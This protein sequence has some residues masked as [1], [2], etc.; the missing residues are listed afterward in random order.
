MQTHFQQHKRTGYRLNQRGLAE[1]LFSQGFLRQQKGFVGPIGDDIPSLIPLTVALLVFFGAFGFAFNS[2]EE[3]K[4]EFDQRLILLSV[5]KTLKGDNLLDNYQKWK[6]ACESIEVTRYKFKAVVFLVSTKPDAT[7]YNYE[8][9]HDW[10]EGPTVPGDDYTRT[11]DLR[12]YNFNNTDQPLV[13]DNEGVHDGMGGTEEIFSSKALA[14]K[15]LRI[16]FP[17][18]LAKDTV[19]RPAILAVM[20]WKS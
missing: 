3:K 18:A 4:A 20:V 2:F 19:F 5:G 17:V 15:T 11:D 8:F 6:D 10:Q 14:Q 9:F 16:N 13:C 7:F 1:G 12:V